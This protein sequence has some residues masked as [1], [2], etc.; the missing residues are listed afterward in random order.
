LKSDS[1]PLFVSETFRRRDG[2]CKRNRV[3]AFRP[4]RLQCASGLRDR[5]ACR[6]NIVHDEN[7]VRRGKQTPECADEIPS[8]D[9]GF[10]PNLRRSLTRSRD[11]LSARNLESCCSRF[12]EQSRVIK[13]TISDPPIRCGYPR[14][15]L[16]IKFGRRA[17]EMNRESL[18]ERE[19]PAV[20]ESQDG[21]P[22]HAFELKTLSGPIK[23]KL[24]PA[25]LAALANRRLAPRTTPRTNLR[26]T[27][28]RGSKASVANPTAHK[29][30]TPETNLRISKIRNRFH[31][32]VTLAAGSDTQAFAFAHIGRTRV[33]P[34]ETGSR[35]CNARPSLALRNDRATG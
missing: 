9:L 21:K 30:P 17:N 32:R 7:V 22:R 35:T 10:Q 3:D 19:L 24:A 8:S 31:H 15:R 28:P 27:K 14:N 33:L 5:R 23:P 16:P 34:K 26:R 25:T 1:L 13:P 11:Q 12:S 2:A 18:G 6:E 20:L 4:G 29:P